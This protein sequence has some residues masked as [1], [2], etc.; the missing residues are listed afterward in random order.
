MA[1]PLRIEYP[2]A[3][4][5]SHEKIL[6]VDD[7]P[8]NLQVLMETLRVRKSKLFVAK[9]GQAA[10]DTAR[11]TKLDLILLDIMMPGMDGFEVCR[12]LKDSP[13]TSGIPII[14]LSAMDRTEDK[15]NGLSL[16]AVDYITKPFQPE[17]VL[18]R[19][20]THLT[21]HRLQREVQNQRDQLEHELQTVSQLQRKLL[22]KTLP[23]RANLDLATFYATSRYA[24]G[25]YY[26][27]HEF[28]DGRLGILVA[29][30]EG[31]SSPAAV[32]MA[33]TCTLF[34]A[35]GGDFGDPE[36][37]LVYLNRYLC[38]LAEPSFVTALYAVYDPQERRLKAGRAGHNYPMLY[39][40]A[41]GKAHEW[42]LAGVMPLAVAFFDTV[43]V[44]EIQLSPED[45]FLF[46]TDGITERFN[47]SGLAYGESRL[48]SSL[49][50]TANMDASGAIDEIM[51]QV[52]AFASPLS[53][54]DDQ[55]LVLGVVN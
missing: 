18:V 35:F 46:Y 23:T 34:K 42:S 47:K 50:Q 51:R 33:M 2:G 48:L 45:R 19:V 4:D 12:R 24:G 21:L 32:L 8:I 17:E 30:A 53:A 16:G 14:F 3:A 54:D 7:N 28:P 44:E 55:A 29:D 6:L 36:A 11:K 15:V 9:D 49:E 31:H 5:A 22:P 25:D 41:T 40:A 10:L 38:A 39:D 43:P 37:L 52:D 26:D 13:A 27:F 1:R 20:E